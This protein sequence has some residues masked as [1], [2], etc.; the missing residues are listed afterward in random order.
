MFLEN[1]SKLKKRSFFEA[2]QAQKLPVFL[3]LLAFGLF[4][5]FYAGQLIKQPSTDFPSFYWG[6]RYAWVDHLNPYGESSFAPVEPQTG[7]SIFPYLYP[8]FSLLLFA[9]LA[10]FS[11]PTARVVMLGVNLACLLGCLYLLLWLYLRPRRVW[12]GLVLA[13]FGLVF[14]PVLVTLDHGQVNLLVLF[15]IL[16]S[17][18]GLEKKIAPFWA[19]LALSAAIVLKTYP[20]ILLAW[21]V[22]KREWRVLGWTFVFLAAA[23]VLSG[24][25]LPGLWAD[26]VV[27][28]LPSGG[29]G[30]TPMGLFSP[31]APWNQGINGFTARLFLENT[32][33]ANFFLSPRVAKV[34]PVALSLGVLFPT[35]FVLA[36]RVLPRQ[37]ALFRKSPLSILSVDTVG[38]VTTSL[39]LEALAALL[40]VMFLITPL[41]WEHHLVFALPAIFLLA[42]RLADRGKVRWQLFGAVLCGLLLALPLPFSSEALRA[43]W[44]VLLISIKF[45]A[46]CG[47]W[48]FLLVETACQIKTN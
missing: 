7:Q 38:Q 23:T 4:F 10:W 29:Y 24:V 46:A 30:L 19:A 2:L 47:L 35:L 44:Q 43:G 6:A 31:A 27:Q 42:C 8:P 26:W 18:A 37:F 16:L 45:Y 41:S 36:L 33:S 48:F 1:P 28:V 22:L 9:P 3:F 20:V 25:L 39:N 14:Q 12:L 5:Y 40:L 17:W 21:F 34:A 15:L 32:Y 13:V 11:Y